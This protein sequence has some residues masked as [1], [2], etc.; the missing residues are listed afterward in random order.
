MGAD[1]HGPICRVK[2]AVKALGYNPDD[3][4]VMLL[5]I[6]SLYRNSELSQNVKTHG[7]KCDAGRAY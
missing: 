3:L 6:V 7:T 2:A 5:Q 1:H 4:E